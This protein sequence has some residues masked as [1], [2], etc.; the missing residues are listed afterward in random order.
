MTFSAGVGAGVCAKAP[1]AA[2]TAAAKP[3]A[4]QPANMRIIFPLVFAHVHH[5]PHD[6]RLPSLTITRS[7]STYFYPAKCPQCREAYGVAGFGLGLTG[8][9]SPR[10]G[11]LNFR[12]TS[13]QNSRKTSKPMSC[14]ML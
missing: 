3:T 2:T 7:S 13:G 9:D 10:K 11:N 4:F 14:R 8:G 6:R 5:D 12:E 1:K